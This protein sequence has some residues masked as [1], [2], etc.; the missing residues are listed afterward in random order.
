M[1]NKSNTKRGGASMQLSIL[2]AGTATEQAYFI[3]PSSI[4]FDGCPWDRDITGN[5]IGYTKA[6]GYPTSV[7][8]SLTK[9][10]DVTFTQNYFTA[11]HIPGIIWLDTVNA[12]TFSQASTIVTWAWSGYNSN[13][14]GA[15]GTKQF[16]L[17]R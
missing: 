5:F 13:P 8:V 4:H 7:R 12:T 14:L 10:S 6:G 3:S 9:P 17:E 1:Y 2:F 16:Y 15:A 11:F